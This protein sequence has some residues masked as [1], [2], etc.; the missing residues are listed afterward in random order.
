MIDYLNNKKREIWMYNLKYFNS[1]KA[2]LRII[3]KV[4][5]AKRE[6][7]PTCLIKYDWWEWD[8]TWYHSGGTNYI[9]NT[10]GE[11]KRRWILT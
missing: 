9:K 11:K 10:R 3:R 6:I 8:V 4:V 5:A 7:R 2:Q 1:H